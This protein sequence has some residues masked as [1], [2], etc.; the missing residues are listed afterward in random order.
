MTGKSGKSGKLGKSG[1]SVTGKKT[2]LLAKKSRK[3][4]SERA[5]LVFPVT[6]LR[7]YMKVIN[8]DKRLTSSAPV[9][10]AAV[11]EYLV[12]ELLELAGNA[13]RDHKKKHIKPR[14]IQLAVRNDDE[15]NKLL[16]DVHIMEGGVIPGIRPELLPK[17]RTASYYHAYDSQEA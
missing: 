12:A 4:R 13:C 3:N 7:R 9:Y 8:A 5:G 16:K 11:L 15:I 2:I 17:A 10:L 14:H 1:K 6:R